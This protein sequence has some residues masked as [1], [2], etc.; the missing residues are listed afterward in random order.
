MWQVAA[1]TLELSTVET[2]RCL[3]TGRTSLDIW[4]GVAV[5]ATEDQK[6][7]SLGKSD[8]LDCRR[9]GAEEMMVWS[10][11]AS[12]YKSQSES[13]MEARVQKAKTSAR[14]RPARFPRNRPFFI[15][16]LFI[17]FSGPKIIIYYIFKPER[18]IPNFHPAAWLYCRHALY[19]CL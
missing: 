19:R 11:R 7:E 10:A 15:F 4:L 6:L 9:L 8:R 18:V 5:S 14:K 17:L 13:A 16:I 12:I 1:P 3:W 2:P